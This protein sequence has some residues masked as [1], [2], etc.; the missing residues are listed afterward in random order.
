MLLILTHIFI[1]ITSKFCANFRHLLYS[2]G[3]LILFRKCCK[4]PDEDNKCRK[5]AQ[6]FEVIDISNKFCEIPEACQYYSRHGWHPPAVQSC[7]CVVCQSVHRIGYI[8]LEH[9]SSS[10]LKHGWLRT[11]SCP[12][13]AKLLAVANRF[14]SLHYQAPSSQQRQSQLKYKNHSSI[15]GLYHM[16]RYVIRTYTIIRSL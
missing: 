2:S 3:I 7:H 15:I 1:S 10:T 6:N 9:E 8:L 5:F 16:I 12:K 13:T 4:K 11:G 14:R